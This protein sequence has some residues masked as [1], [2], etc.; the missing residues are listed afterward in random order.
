MIV[1]AKSIIEEK[2][3]RDKRKKGAQHIELHLLLSDV[4]DKKQ[5][6]T[7][8]I[9]LKNSRMK[10]VTVHSP[11][12]RI[13]TLEGILSKS[14]FELLDNTCYLAQKIANYR[15]KDVNVVIHHELDLEQMMMWDLIDRIGDEINV[16]L[17]RYK[18]VI[19][20]VE[21]LMPVC[22]YKGSMYFANSYV[23]SQID[24]CEHLRKYLRTNRIGVVVDTGHI[25]A[26]SRILE[27][28]D[29]YKERLNLEDI[30][31]NSKEYLNIVHLSNSRGLGFGDG[32]GCGFDTDRERER[33]RFI[34]DTLKEIEFNGSLVLEVN[35]LNYLDSV[36]FE[37]LFKQVN[38]LI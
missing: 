26:S 17:H 31:I 7:Q 19:I 10:I 13:C 29:G 33:L 6:Q 28:L 15:G 8:I 24:I 36:E 20:N 27:R 30:L 21:N 12:E 34:I 9:T 38:N 25:L 3:L 18:N 11:I 2:N 23:Q 32:Y 5:V 1:T 14:G 4:Y 37:K 22:T 35:E 16:L